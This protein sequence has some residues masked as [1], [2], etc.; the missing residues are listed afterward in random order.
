MFIRTQHNDIVA[1]K[2]E[3]SLNWVL[4]FMCIVFYM[5]C[6]LYRRCKVKA[7]CYSYY[8]TIFI[9]SVGEHRARLI[10]FENFEI[11]FQVCYVYIKKFL[12]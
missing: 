5:Y 12:D 1:E 4:Y 11:K 3:G 7:E 2:I 10:E 9:D 8:L 6:I